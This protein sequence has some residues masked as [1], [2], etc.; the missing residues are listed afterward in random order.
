MAGVVVEQTAWA[1]APRVAP[2]IRAMDWAAPDAFMWLERIP[3]GYI[4][5]D[6]CEECVRLAHLD[7]GVPF[8]VWQAGRV[9]DVRQELRWQSMG[10]EI[11][12]VWCGAEPMP[13]GFT[14]EPHGGVAADDL[15][16]YLWGRR[17]KPD[18]LA[19]LGIQPRADE[20]VFMQL[21]IPRVL[22]YPL[23]GSREYA[24]VIVREFYAANGEL[25]YA[26][27]CGLEEAE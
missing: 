21:Q 13:A 8:D 27:L 10:G 15:R 11:L 26:R 23:S 5:E 24:R 9:F 4:E 1:R 6:E 22:R 16:Y 18:A 19:Q 14:T 7:P 20:S 2:L 3:T 25:A 12:A 17:V